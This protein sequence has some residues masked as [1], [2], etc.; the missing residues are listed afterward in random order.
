MIKCNMCN[1][2]NVSVFLVEEKVKHNFLFLS[3][4]TEY[5]ICNNCNR[6]FISK[7]QIKKNETKLIE[8]KKYQEMTNK[9]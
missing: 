7:E 2:N 8:Q 1:S 9:N 5:S 3:V 4:Q 6:E